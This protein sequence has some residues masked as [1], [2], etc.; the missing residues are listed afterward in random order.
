MNDELKQT[1]HPWLEPENVLG[2]QAVLIAAG[3]DHD[4]T[5]DWLEVLLR[6]VTFCEVGAVEDGLRADRLEA[7]RRVGVWSAVDEAEDAYLRARREQR[8][9]MR[10]S[11]KQVYDTVR[12]HLPAYE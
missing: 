4:D 9:R 8:E 3:H 2:W 11:A 12:E 5:V 6:L 10:E 1:V 7:S